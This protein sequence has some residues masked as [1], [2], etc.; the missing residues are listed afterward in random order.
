MGGAV[1]AG[2]D[3]AVDAGDAGI[4]CVETG[5]TDADATT[6]DAGTI[7]AGTIDVGSVYCS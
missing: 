6:V 5:T 7:E 4:A 1:I 2:A 3:A